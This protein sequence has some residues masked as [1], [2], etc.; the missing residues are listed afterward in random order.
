MEEYRIKY[1][2]S[3]SAMDSYH[4]YMA[5]SAIQALE[6]Q[7]IMCKQKELDIEILSIERK[8]RYMKK[9]INESKILA[10]EAE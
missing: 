6:F 2:S 9:W 4:Y 10:D 5:D 3:N 1:N 8:C 7:K